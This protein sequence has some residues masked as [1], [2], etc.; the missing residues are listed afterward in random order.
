MVLRTLCPSWISP[1]EGY[2]LSNTS[3]VSVIQIDRVILHHDGAISRHGLRS[4]KD[5]IENAEESID[6]KPPL[7][8]LHKGLTFS[9]FLSALKL[10]RVS[11]SPPARGRPP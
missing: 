8:I 4:I 6:E 1:V 11:H 10:S 3:K 9:T 2:P 7:C 5:P